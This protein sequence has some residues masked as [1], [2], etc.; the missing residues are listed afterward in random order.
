MLLHPSVLWWIYSEQGGCM[1]HRLRL[2]SESNT[3]EEANP[4]VMHLGM[5]STGLWEEADTIAFSEP[6]VHE[7]IITWSVFSKYLRNYT[8]A[9]HSHASLPVC[10]FI[11]LCSFSWRLP[12]F[13]EGILSVRPSIYLL[14]Y[15]SISR[16]IYPSIDLSFFQ[17]FYHAY[18]SFYYSISWNTWCSFYLSF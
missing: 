4:P 13:L 2:T 16:S 9:V 17:S 5:S 7:D 12:Q 6:A 8:L 1:I 14:S 3:M 11:S 18:L 15:H 10:S